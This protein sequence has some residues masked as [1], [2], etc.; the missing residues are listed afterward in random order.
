MPNSHCRPNTL[1]SVVGTIALL[2]VFA[3]VSPAATL[4]ADQSGK[5][6][7]EIYTCEWIQRNPD[8][9]VEARVT[10]DPATFFGPIFT[11]DPVRIQA[12]PLSQGCANVPSSGSVGQG[13]YAWSSDESSVA[14]WSG[15]YVIVERSGRTYPSSGWRAGSSSSSGSCTS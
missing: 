10:C 14:A 1:A 2:A 13:V 5:P 12:Q 4:S 7:G 6:P 3:L 8:A 9:A 11:P 15:T